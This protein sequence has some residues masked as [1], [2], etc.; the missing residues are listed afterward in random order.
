MDL[1]ERLLKLLQAPPDVLAKVDAVLTGGRASSEEAPPLMRINEAA[2]FCACSRATIYRL[3]AAGK[4]RRTHL[5]SGTPRIYR[6]DLEALI[7]S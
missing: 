1:N 5:L 6:N 2:K 3:M 7:D 4:I